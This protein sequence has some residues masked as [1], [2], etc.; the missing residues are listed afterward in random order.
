MLTR[1]EIVGRRYRKPVGPV[2]VLSPGDASFERHLDNA[3][4]DP[5]YD[6]VFTRLRFTPPAEADTLARGLSAEVAR[7]LEES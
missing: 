7:R 4:R 3:I 1:S 5:F 2:R 6:A